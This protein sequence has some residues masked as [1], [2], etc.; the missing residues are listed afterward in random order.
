[1]VA[2]AGP[3]R[4]SVIVPTYNWSGALRVA[5]AS[6]R[7]QT[8]TDY[9]VLVVGDAC[10]DDSAEAVRELRDKRF[11][12]HNLPQR[13]GSQWGPN[14]EGL[15]RARGEYVAYLG[16]DDLWWLTHLETALATFDRTGADMVAAGAILYGPRGSGVRA[17]TGFFPHNRFTRRHF[18][19]PSSMLHRRDLAARIGGWR[20]AQDSR[21][22]VDY[23]FLVRCQQAG[24][25]IAATDE[26]TA[27]KFSAAW[28]RDAYL[29]RDA[30]DQETALARMRAEGEAFRRRELTDVVRAATENR[31]ALVETP[32][33]VP[34]TPPAMELMQSFKGSRPRASSRYAQLPDGRLRFS[35]DGAYAGFEWHALEAHPAFGNFR[36]SGPA[37]ESS[38]IL[39]VKV[40]TAL[41][42]R[43]LVVSSIAADTLANAR[44][45][46][47]GTPLQARLEPAE[48]GAL[49]W[50]GIIRPDQLPADDREEVRLCFSLRETHRPIDLGLSEDRRWLGVAIGDIEV[51]PAPA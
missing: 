20:S 12:W 36:W 18:F 45:S 42:V 23:D 10:T 2:G 4:V 9:E 43:A 11:S 51:G 44:I 1:L 3:P 34:D 40:D 28:R 30:S 48:S 14:N 25:R 26:I 15:A 13:C 16:H 8:F 35:P 7:D 5:L 21:G 27:F 37:I 47:N 33:T 39:P 46:V 31:F 38:V 49:R 19:P 6:I 24:A 17:A 41:E 29:T 50:I 22:S 32:L